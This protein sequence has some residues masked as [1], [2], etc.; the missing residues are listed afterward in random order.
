MGAIASK[1][2]S[3][4]ASVS[5][6]MASASDGAVSGPVAM[7]VV[8]HS[9]GGRPV[10]SSRSDGDERMGFQSG[11]YG[12]R[13]AF[14]VNGQ[15]TASGNLM[16][17][18]AS[19]DER[20]G[21]AHLGMENTDGVGF[22]VVGAEGVGADELC[23]L[24]GLVRIGAA[25]RAHFVQHD[26]YAGL[27]DLPGGFA[28]GKAAANDVNGERSVLFDM[29]IPLS[30][31]ISAFN[32]RR[33]QKPGREMQKEMASVAGG[34]RRMPLGEDR[35]W[36]ENRLVIAKSGRRWRALRRTGP[37]LGGGTRPGET[38]D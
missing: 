1:K 6:A 4:S 10:I 21:K 18:R 32:G 31:L 27:C 35:H 37:E 8:P 22:C 17:I 25:N 15:R 16:G 36:E 12:L 23:K 24:F 13:K 14:T 28:A 29:A 7:I 20:S 11:G 30:P 19:H 38:C 33:D 26:R 3:A 5:A 2:A 9:V 34:G